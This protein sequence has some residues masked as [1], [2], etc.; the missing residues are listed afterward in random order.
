MMLNRN[1]NEGW[2]KPKPET[3]VLESRHGR[4]QAGEANQCAEPLIQT[5]LYRLGIL[6]E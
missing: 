3:R 1:P 2:L 4:S 6:G 5:L